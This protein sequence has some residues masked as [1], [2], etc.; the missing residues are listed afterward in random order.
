MSDRVD[1][2]PAA[3][4][5]GNQTSDRVTSFSSEHCRAVVK[6]HVT[7]L[8]IDQKGEETWHDEQKDKDRDST[9]QLAHPIGPFFGLFFRNYF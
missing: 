3:S 6:T 1:I 9:T 7:F 2:F 4:G 5:L 8:T